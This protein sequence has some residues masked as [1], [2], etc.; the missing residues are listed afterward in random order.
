[1]IASPP[2]Q[3]LLQQGARRLRNPQNEHGGW[4]SRSQAQPGTPEPGRA[5][6]PISST[7]SQT[8]PNRRRKATCAHRFSSTA[9]GPARVHQISSGNGVQVREE[10]WWTLAGP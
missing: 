2:F 10:I 9:N 6:A 4:Y 7:A 5:P 8:K 1:N 3:P